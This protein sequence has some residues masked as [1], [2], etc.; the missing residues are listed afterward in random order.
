M[1][2]LDARYLPLLLVGLF[3]LLVLFTMLICHYI[4]MKHTTG[5]GQNTLT[6][7]ILTTLL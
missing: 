3:A 1:T 4:S 2:R 5:F 7:V 6:L